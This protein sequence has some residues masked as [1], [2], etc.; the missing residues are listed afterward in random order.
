M[1]T[2]CTSTEGFLK[3]IYSHSKQQFE[4]GIHESY[5]ILSDSGYEL[6]NY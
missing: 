1:V 5:I 3:I 4:K 2:Q 6:I